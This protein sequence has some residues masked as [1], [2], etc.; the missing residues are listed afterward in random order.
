[1]N[2]GLGFTIRRQARQT[3]R[4][5]RVHK[6][7]G[8]VILLRL[9]PTP[10][11]DDAVTFRYR[12]ES[13]YLNRTHTSLIKQTHKRTL[14]WLRHPG[15]KQPV[16]PIAGVTVGDLLPRLFLWAEGDQAVFVG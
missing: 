3:D 7:Y 16:P 10:S 11:H 13:A 5:N 6:S 1:M 14:L 12:P 8:L 2:N 15:C 9:L 4:P